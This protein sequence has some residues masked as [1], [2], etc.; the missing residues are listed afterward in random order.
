M[1]NLGEILFGKKLPELRLGRKAMRVIQYEGSNRIETIRE[2]VGAKGYAS[3]FEGLIGFINGLVPTNE[4]V[5]QALRRDVPRFPMLAVRELVANALIHQDFL[6]TGSGPMVE[7][8]DDRIEIT[9]PGVPLVDAE[10]FVDSPPRSRNEILASFMRRI[11]VCEER[12]SGWDK[13]AFQSEV[14]QL[15]AP[16]VEVTESHTRVSLFAPRP[17]SGM[18]RVE[19]IRATYLHACLR[20]VSREYLTNRSVRGRFGIDAKNSARAS[21]LIAEAVQAGVIA[22]DD[23]DAA[24]KMMRY[25][26]RWAKG[27]HDMD[28]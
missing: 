8:F 28:T 15:P 23:E 3:G 27:P 13:I 18:D 16:L 5:Q 11:G 7:I 17:L 26:P 1:T 24:P 9:N 4:V 19:R 10:R 14:Y 2:Q 6:A 25:V 22:P 12:G 21:R 20:Y